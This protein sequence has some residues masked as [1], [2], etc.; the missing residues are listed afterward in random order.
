ML[1][2]SNDGYDRAITMFSPDGR[3]FQVEYAIEAVRHG[4]TAVG[5]K[6]NEGISLVAERRINNKLLIPSTLDRIVLIDH[7]V[8]ASYAGLRADTFRLLDYARMLAQHERMEFDEPISLK[9]LT[10]QLCKV[11]QVY[12][13]HAMARPFGTS[14]MLAGFNGDEPSLTTTGPSGGSW[15]W[16][17]AVIGSGE[18]QGN[19]YLQKQ[20]SPTASLDETVNLGIKILKRL[21]PKPIKKEAL[22]IGILPKDTKVFRKLDAP[23]IET[24]LAGI[25]KENPE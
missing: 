22:E 11:I 9:S 2:P 18:T 23:E 7:H 12:T 14:L 15:T 20:Y 5:V 1:G 4:S 19:E 13:Q 17:A 16:K 21:K 25:E 6:T 24:I 3:L 8:G 10:K